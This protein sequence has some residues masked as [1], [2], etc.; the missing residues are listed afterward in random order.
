M[1]YVEP[2]FEPLFTQYVR[3]HPDLAPFSA[4]FHIGFADGNNWRSG[5]YG[6]MI[7]RTCGPPNTPD[8]PCGS[9]TNVGLRSSNET[10]YVHQVSHFNVLKL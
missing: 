10:M 8:V 9:V 4:R 7:D 3:D 2:S 5:L 1:L 6:W